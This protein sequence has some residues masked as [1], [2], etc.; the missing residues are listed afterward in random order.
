[1]GDVLF[2]EHQNDEA[3][4]TYSEIVEF[5]PNNPLARQWLGDILY[6]RGW[7]DA[8]YRQYQTLAELNPKDPLAVLRVANAAA[9]AGRVLEALKKEHEVA[10][11]DGSPGAQDP[12][13]FARMLSASRLAQLL[14]S[15]PAGTTAIDLT[16]KLKELQLQT[17]D[18][19]VLTFVVWKDLNAR[20]QLVAEADVG[21]ATDAGAVGLYSVVT[22]RD[23]FDKAKWQ[24]RWRDDP[25]RDVDLTVVSLVWDGK[26]FHAT[27]KAMTLSIKDKSLS[28]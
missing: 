20:I 17:G 7:Y 3:L 25:R 4:R 11:A 13:M 26:E 5:D 2:E 9:G 16:R 28:L 21:E 23:A 6:R 27:T 1:L 12:R 14:A 24:L 15:P 22:S 8:A 18:S 10:N 19:S